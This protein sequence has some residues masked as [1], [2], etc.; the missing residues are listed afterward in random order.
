MRD[1]FLKEIIDVLLSLFFTLG[2]QGGVFWAYRAL[3]SSK[4]S[5]WCASE[6][7]G[8]EVEKAAAGDAGV[9]G[10]LAKARRQGSRPARARR[11][12]VAVVDMALCV[13]RWAGGWSGVQWCWV[14]G[15][16]E[17]RREVLLLRGRSRRS[18][19]RERW[20]VR[21]SQ[22]IHLGGERRERI[23]SGNGWVS[24]DDGKGEWKEDRDGGGEERVW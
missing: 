15:L 5:S 11:A 24:R 6:R 19:W 9:A 21:I 2:K 16:R 4:V 20:S 12:R 8:R 18:L 17:G 14:C 23:W 10:V 7:Q 13:G 3:N 22:K 1:V